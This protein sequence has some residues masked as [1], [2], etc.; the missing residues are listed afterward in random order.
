MAR[1]ITDLL[2]IEAPSGNFSKGRIKDNDGTQNGTPNNEKLHGDWTQFFQKLMDEAG[3]SPNGN[4][5][6]QVNNQLYDALIRTTRLWEGY[7]D[8]P[9]TIASSGSFIGLEISKTSIEINIEPINTITTLSAANLYP[10]G[11]TSVIFVNLGIGETL[12][13]QLN[14]TNILSGQIPIKKSGNTT[15]NDNVSISPNNAIKVTKFENYWLLE[16]L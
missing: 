6:D 15:T 12:D 16:E 11:Q 10:K 9:N 1:S 5:D 8:N 4:A 14:S 13:I 2:N 3:I 7:D